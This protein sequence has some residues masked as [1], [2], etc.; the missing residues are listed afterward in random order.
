MVKIP[1]TSTFK[2]A[3]RCEERAGLWTRHCH[4]AAKSWRVNVTWRRLI[5]ITAPLSSWLAIISPERRKSK[6]KKFVMPSFFFL[7][8]GVIG[9]YYTFKDSISAPPFDSRDGSTASGA[10]QES[11]G[12]A[13]VKGTDPRH[14]PNG[15]RSSPIFQKNFDVLWGSWK[16]K[17]KNTHIHFIICLL[18]AV[19]KEVKRNN[20]QTRKI[21]N[22]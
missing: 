1:W 16:N 5:P 21:L 17:N 20:K 8:Y 7:C 10:A 22:S 11:N 12:G 14:V 15:R 2:W 13:L 19:T 9:I 18:Q 3:T 6:D 4:W